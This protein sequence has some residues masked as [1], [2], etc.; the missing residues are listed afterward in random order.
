MSVFRDI[1][2]RLEIICVEWSCN[3]N[4]MGKGSRQ[5]QEMVTYLVSYNDA[6]FRYECVTVKYQ[7]F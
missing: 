2:L 3:F 4:G 5:N 6:A 1:V 7:F